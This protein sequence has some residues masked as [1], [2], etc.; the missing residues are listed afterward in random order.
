MPPESLAL[1]ARP[2]TLPQTIADALREAIYAGRFRPGGRIP[3]AIVARE[4]G[5]SQTT[6]RDAFAQLEREGI[7]ERGDRRGATVIRLSREDIEEIVTLR[8]VLEA[9]AMRRVVRGDTTAV[10]AELEANLAAMKQCHDGR[11]L[12][13]LDLDFH[14]IFV[15]AAGHKRLYSCW[16]GLL[17]P[18]K[19]LMMAH[20]QQDPNVLAG[21]MANHRKL[22]R[23]IRANDEANAVA[24]LEG[25]SDVYLVRLLRPEGAQGS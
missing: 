14:E 12:A 25:S 24:L 23:F 3:Q 21:T 7:V 9:T 10:V 15:R 6:V 8:T 11:E 19:L 17:P 13:V 16:Q 1:A 5:V 20:H 4:L 18:L 2:R 22:V